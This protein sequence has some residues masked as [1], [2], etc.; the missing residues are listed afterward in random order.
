MYYDFLAVVDAGVFHINDPSLDTE[1]RGLREAWVEA[2]SYGENYRDASGGRHIF[3]RPG[4]AALTRA[5][6][7][8]WN[9]IDSARGDM[10]RHLDTLLRIVRDDYVEIDPLE[11]SRVALDRYRQ[12]REKENVRYGAASEG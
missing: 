11:T 1:V 3:S 5:E 4:D 12:E 6:E 2:M 9:A 7:A 8:D 10:K